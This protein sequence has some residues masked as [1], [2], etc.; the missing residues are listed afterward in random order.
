M[1]NKNLL[2]GALI[3]GL[4][5]IGCNKSSE[6][7]FNN[8]NGDV[9]V[10]YIRS[11]DIINSDDPSENRTYTLHYDGESRVSQGNFTPNFSQNRT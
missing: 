9:A 11:V 3:F 10:K 4:L 7:E 5:L 6:D 8:A 1:N 2:L